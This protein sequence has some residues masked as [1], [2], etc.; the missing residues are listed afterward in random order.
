MRAFGLDEIEVSEQD[1]L[2]GSALSAALAPALERRPICVHTVRTGVE[3]RASV[4]PIR[5]NIGLPQFWVLAFPRPLPILRGSGE[6]VLGRTPSTPFSAHRSQAFAARRLPSSGAAHT[7]QVRPPRR[8][9]ARP[10]G[11]Y[12]DRTAMDWRSVSLWVVSARRARP[13]G[14]AS[15]ATRAKAL[16]ASSPATMPA[17]PGH[18]QG[19]ARVDRLGEPAGERGADRGRA[20]EDDRVERHHP[21]AHLRV[22]GELQRGVDRGREDDAGGARAAPARRARA[23]S[24]ARPAASSAKAPKPIAAPAS[25]AGLTLPRAPVDERAGDRADPHRADQ[26]RVGAGAAVEGELGEQ[27]QDRLEVEAERADRGHQRQRDPEL[28]GRAHVAER[29]PHGAR[30]ARA[31]SRR[32]AG[33]RRPSSP[34]RRSSPRSWR[35]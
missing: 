30:L 7:P 22:G 26:R 4:T 17:T 23:P 10:D 29:R 1:I 32:A 20:E 24:T 8:T 16:R 33:R 35:R 14:A 34:G 18:D 25:S 21:A 3:F 6:L 12:Q 27:R 13:A 15:V 31:R 2:H 28:G 5:T 9:P 19:R 11:A